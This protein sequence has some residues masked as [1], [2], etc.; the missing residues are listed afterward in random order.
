MIINS[1]RTKDV[2]EYYFSKKLKE[3]SKLINQGEPIINMGIGSPDIFPSVKVIKAL[4][5]S[6][7]DPSAHK[8]QSYYPIVN[9]V[10]SNF[11]PFSNAL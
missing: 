7:N 1:N 5:M 2:Q 8:Y 9:I 10:Y 3:I 4:K 11:G 6:L